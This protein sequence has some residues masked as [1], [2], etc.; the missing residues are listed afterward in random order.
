[1]A[2]SPDGQTALSGSADKT[3]I[4]WDVASGQPI[5]TLRG[6]TKRVESVAF[7]PDGQTA[8]SGSWDNTLILWDVANGEPLHTFT[9]HGGSV[10]SVA[11][12]P[13]RQTALSGSYDDTLILWSIQTEEELIAWVYANRAVEPLTCVQRAMYNVTPLC[14]DA[15]NT[16]V[17]TPRPT[18]TAAP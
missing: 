12:S 11:F 8:L 6:H 1:M 16:P 2:F 4:L 3:L 17:L 5:R 14:D 7:S 9:E 10:F 15:G 13:N 18:G